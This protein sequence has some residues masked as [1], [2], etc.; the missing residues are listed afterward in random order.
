MPTASL[1]VEGK[2]IEKVELAKP[3]EV[4]RLEAR[5]PGLGPIG[6]RSLA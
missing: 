5:K 6:T 2:Q 4:R 1:W 3:G